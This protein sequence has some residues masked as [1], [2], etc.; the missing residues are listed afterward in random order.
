MQNAENFYR[1]SS[2]TVDNEIW[3]TGQN[4]FASS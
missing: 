3:Q 4:K 1:V 2:E